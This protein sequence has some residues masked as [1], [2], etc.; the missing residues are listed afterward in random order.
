MWRMGVPAEESLGIAQ[1]LES[2]AALHNSSS[3]GFRPQ[4]LPFR[5][6]MNHMAASLPIAQLRCPK[7]GQK[8]HG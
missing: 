1:K 4:H 8:R 5:A 2:S 6:G 3:V 7:S